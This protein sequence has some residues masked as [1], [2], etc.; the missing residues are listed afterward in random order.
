[1]FQ[2]YKE[3]SQ[4]HG[5]YT[6]VTLNKRNVHIFV[7]WLVQ[8]TSAN[9]WA[10]FASLLSLTSPNWNDTRKHFPKSFIFTGRILIW[11][12]HLFSYFPCVDNN[13]NL[14]CSQY[15]ALKTVLW[16]V[17]IL[18]RCWRFKYSLSHRGEGCHVLGF[19][20]CRFPV[21]FLKSN[22]SLVSGHLP[23]LWP[24]LWLLAVRNR[25]R[26]RQY[27]VDWE[28]YGPEERQWVPSRHIMDP[29][30]ITDFPGPPWTTWA[31]RCRP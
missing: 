23:F 18:M 28:V 20:S 16:V 17:F 25:G 3:K 22:F 31:V 1:M 30:L 19:L 27:L 5:Y 9:R 10:M 2:N 11:I 21:L 24:F 29:S 13:C 15:T 26:G 12:H 6:F 7:T 4:S 8:V 14:E